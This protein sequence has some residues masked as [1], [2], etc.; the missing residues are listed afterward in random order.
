[1]RTYADLV[2][3]HLGF[4][5]NL[6]YNKGDKAGD[7]VFDN[8]DSMPKVPR[9]A[10]TAS[11]AY[12]GNIIERRPPPLPTIRKIMKDWATA[13]R[14]AKNATK[15]LNEN[16]KGEKW[17]EQLREH[18]TKVEQKAKRV[19]EAI[20]ADEAPEVVE[21]E[22]R[23]LSDAATD[24]AIFSVDASKPD[25][26][27]DMIKTCRKRNA[28]ATS[29]PKKLKKLTI[30]EMEKVEKKRV[31][32]W[33]MVEATEDTAMSAKALKKDLKRQ[34][35]YNEELEKEQLDGGGEKEKEGGGGK[36][37]LRKSSSLPLLDKMKSSSTD[38]TG[39]GGEKEKGRGAGEKEK[40]GGG[41]KSSLR[42]SSSQPLLD[43]MKSSSTDTTGTGGGKEKELELEKK[44]EKDGG[45]ESEGVGNG[46]GE[47]QHQ[48]DE[49][50]KKA[51]QVMYEMYDMNNM[52]KQMVGNV[53]ETLV[54][55]IDWE[56]VDREW[57][58]RE[59]IL[60]KEAAEKYIIGC[61]ESGLRNIYKKIKKHLAITSDNG[62]MLMEN[63][64][65]ELAAKLF[66]AETDEEK[67][68]ILKEVAQEATYMA[69]TEEWVEEK[70]QCEEEVKE[71]RAGLPVLLA[72]TADEVAMK[73]IA[74]I[75]EQLKKSWMED[76]NLT[77]LKA[78]D[79]E[80]TKVTVNLWSA[81]IFKDNLLI[82]QDM[83][84]DIKEWL[85]K[86]GLL[87]EKI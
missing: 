77:E 25:S 83:L 17:V 75:E 61:D 13:S 50:G 85:R 4:G 43:K 55:E 46:D 35:D 53:V 32:T 5:N 38:T 63:E 54:T 80:E 51:I 22:A 33:K 72:K 28:H 45:D 10:T 60:W 47:T 6:V 19:M 30:E 71:I 66:E 9:L 41:G 64:D 36:S 1:V 76:S 21:L 29:Q 14:N 20:V 74:F 87:R 27:E 15:S 16:E 73:K 2:D 23:E 82:A 12:G 79:L 7:T 39:T 69:V 37:S 70:Q 84:R 58:D 81:T 56:K 52:N 59:L 18:V 48:D 49:E 44:K 34:Y 65:E 26:V 62:R 24:A 57:L 40:K 68:S 3:D 86:V 31:A 8:I 11:Y 42:K 78:L 67:K